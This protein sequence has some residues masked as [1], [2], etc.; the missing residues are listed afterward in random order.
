[1][2]MNLMERQGLSEGE[3]YSQYLIGLKVIHMVQQVQLFVVL[4]CD[5]EHCCQ[6]DDELLSNADTVYSENGE[7]DILIIEPTQLQ[8]QSGRESPS[9]SF[10]S[11]GG[12]VDPI[13]G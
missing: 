10:M 7:P 8:K 12:S 5:Q 1:M 9:L 11:L 3:C 2:L 4:S 13:C 6:E